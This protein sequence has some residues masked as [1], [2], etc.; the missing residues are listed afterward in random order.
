MNT[1]PNLDN[2]KNEIQTSKCYLD[3]RYFNLFFAN[4]P[5]L[6]PNPLYIRLDYQNNYVEHKIILKDFKFRNHDINILRVIVET[7]YWRHSGV[8]LI[9][10]LNPNDIRG[11][12]FDVNIKSQRGNVIFGLIKNMFNFPIELLRNDINIETNPQCEKSG[13]CVAYNIKFLHDYLSDK[14]YD[15]TDIRRFATAVEKLYGPLDSNNPDIE[16]G[17]P[18]GTVTGG[19]VGFGS[20][21]LIGGLVG[22]PAGLVAGGLT[23]G[24]I[25]GGLGTFF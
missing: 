13:F 22:G 4:Y 3:G 15:F 10:L 19:L 8:L 16:Y 7:P 21:A 14:E 24:L 5:G 18:E 9:D 17:W 20:G 12:Y 23:G 1:F 6:I 25:G 11:F 2:Y